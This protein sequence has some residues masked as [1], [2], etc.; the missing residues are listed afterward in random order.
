VVLRH[1][2]DG[3]ILNLVNLKVVKSKQNEGADCVG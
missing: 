1:I 3:V 2:K